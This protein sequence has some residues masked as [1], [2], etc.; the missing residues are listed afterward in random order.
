MN[1]YLGLTIILFAIMFEAFFSGTETAVISVNKIKL[2]HFVDAKIKKA[3]LLQD[4]LN[5]PDKFL[6]TVLVGTNLSVII[7]SVVCTDLIVTRLGPDYKWL[8]TVILTPFILIFAEILPKTVFR[9]MADRV[10]LN[11]VAPLSFF[12][13]VL[14]PISWLASRVSE[15]LL[16]PFGKDKPARK[17]V[18]VSREELKYLLKESERDGVIQSHE[19]AII[20]SI[21]E[22]GAKKVSQVM[23]PLKSAVTIEASKSLS[24]LKDLVKKTGFTRIPVCKDNC[25]DCPGVVNIFDCLHEKDINRPVSDFIRPTIFIYEKESADKALLTL[26]LKRQHLAVVTNDANKNVGILSIEDLLEEIVGEI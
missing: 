10:T 15:A 20:Y 22:F 2:R 12:S 17:S 13:R 4:M 23:L 9:Q 11:L 6:G 3:Q 21:F 26:Q 19:Q 16:L 18:F 24:E 1:I 8:V 5:N 7:S 25:S 14:S